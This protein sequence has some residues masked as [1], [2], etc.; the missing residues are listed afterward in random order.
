MSTLEVQW[1]DLSACI[2]YGWTKAMEKLL[3]SRESPNPYDETGGTPCI[4]G[5]NL[6]WCDQARSEH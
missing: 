6:E 2:E 1:I 5:E 4:L 3:E